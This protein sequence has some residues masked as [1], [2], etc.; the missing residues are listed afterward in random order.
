MFSEVGMNINYTK[1]FFTDQT[2]HLWS[3]NSI[4]TPCVTG[5]WN[6]NVLR[7]LADLGITAT[8]SDE[9]VTNAKTTDYVPQTPYHGVYSTVAAN[10]YAGIYFV[11][12]EA[13]DIDYCDT[14]DAMLVDEYNSQ[15]LSAGDKKLTFEEIMAI[16][17]MYGIEDKIGFR[18]DPFMLHQANAATFS[19]KDPVAGKTRNVSLVSLWIER[20]VDELMTYFN[21]PIVSPQMSTLVQTFQQRQT[22]DS[23]GITTTLNIDS[24]NNVVG[25][26][27]VSTQTCKMSLSGVVLSGSAVSMETLGVETTAWIDLTANVPQ[28]FT[29]ATPHKI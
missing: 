13:L 29:L 4:I 5:L 7:A 20:V 1:T 17:T 6:G 24:N 27:V 10:G 11:P 18:H 26:N 16:Q 14:N 28:S 8:V 15:F 25:I 23:C 21:L 2:I 22:M 12:R 9:S 3:A 19:Y